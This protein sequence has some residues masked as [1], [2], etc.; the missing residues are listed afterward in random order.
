MSGTE[1]SGIE[2]FQNCRMLVEEISNWQKVELVQERGYVGYKQQGHWRGA[3][4]ALGSTHS[5]TVCPGCCLW[6]FRI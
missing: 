3:V 6:S 1:T 5:V 2:R 4:Q